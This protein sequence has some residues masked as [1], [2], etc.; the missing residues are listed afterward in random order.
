MNN[1]SVY[2]E[3]NHWHNVLQDAKQTEIKK[4]LVLR[5]WR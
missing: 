2:Y 4:I 5:T 3:N 1:I